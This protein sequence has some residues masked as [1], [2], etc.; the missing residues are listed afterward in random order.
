MPWFGMHLIDRVRNQAAATKRRESLDNPAQR[1]EPSNTDIVVE[2]LPAITAVAVF[3]VAAGV[4]HAVY[5]FYRVVDAVILLAAVLLLTL[6]S[7][8]AWGQ[9]QG[10]FESG[11]DASLVVGVVAAMLLL[12]TAFA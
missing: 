11:V 4:F 6:S 7:G 5:R 1:S 3:A 10:R 2:S 9:R 12:V 8:A